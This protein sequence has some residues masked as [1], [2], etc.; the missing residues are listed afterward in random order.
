[1]EDKQ[2]YSTAWSAEFKKQVEKYQKDFSQWLEKRSNQKKDRPTTPKPSI[3]NATIPPVE[4]KAA[5]YEIPVKQVAVIR[6]QGKEKHSNKVLFSDN[7]KNLITY[8]L[9]GFIIF[10]ILLGIY[11]TYRK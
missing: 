4:P 11:L 8:S 1:M 6:S 3:Q 5:H 7:L 10:F 9:F 2:V